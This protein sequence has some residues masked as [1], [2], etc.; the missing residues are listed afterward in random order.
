MLSIAAGILLLVGG[1]E[2]LVRGA[3][4]IARALGCPRWS[5]A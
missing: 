3:S 4:R 5:S 1:G 2:I